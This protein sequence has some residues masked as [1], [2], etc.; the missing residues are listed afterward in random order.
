MPL[1][2]WPRGCR[3]ARR[4][5]REQPIQGILCDAAPMPG[6]SARVELESPDYLGSTREAG[7]ACKARIRGAN[8][9]RWPQPIV[10][11]LQLVVPPPLT[12]QVL[13]QL[14]Q[15]LSLIVLFG[16]HCPLGFL[17]QHLQLLYLLLGCGQLQSSP[18]KLLLLFFSL[19][20]RR[21]GCLLVSHVPQ[22]KGHG[23]PHATRAAAIPYS[24]QVCIPPAAMRAAAM[25]FDERDAMCHN[26]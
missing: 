21:F 1:A 14:L 11:L 9:K 22:G 4:L 7:A 18:S 12:R 16:C 23:L 3:H 2:H 25:Y 17:L 8:S 19:L 26:Q 15:L 20:S 5:C 13:L 24:R 6:R 10:E